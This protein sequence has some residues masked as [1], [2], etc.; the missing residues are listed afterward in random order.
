MAWSPDGTTV[1][2]ACENTVRLWDVSS[3]TLKNTL[4]G[5][6]DKVTHI[7]WRC[8]TELSPSP[9]L[10]TASGDGTVRM[11]RDGVCARTIVTTGC[12]NG[13]AWSP[14]GSLLAAA[15]KD[16]TVRVW[17]ALLDA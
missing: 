12:V 4:D 2:T 7:S 16:H 3:G 15:S 14:K 13:V 5:H 9:L 11:W 1:A 17:R 8:S 10:A 6:T